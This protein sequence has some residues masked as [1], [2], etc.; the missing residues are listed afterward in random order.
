M[1]IRRS[2]RQNGATIAERF[3]DEPEAATTE[4]ADMTSTD[5]NNQNPCCLEDIAV[6]EGAPP[7][8]TAELIADTLETWQPYY[9]DPLTANDALE[10]LLSVGHLIDALE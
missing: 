8:I 4:R 10:I 7:W 2:A 3:Q 6:P 9:S 1:A 5:S